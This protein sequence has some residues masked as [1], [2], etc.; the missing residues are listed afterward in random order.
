[1]RDLT[2]QRF[3]KLLVLSEAGRDHLGKVLWR[4]QCDCGETTTT[5]MGNLTQGTTKSCGCLRRVSRRR[6]DLTGRRFGLL[7]A[8]RPAGTTKWA[9]VCDCGVLKDV[10]TIH[11]MREHTRSC[12]CLRIV[13]NPDA[14]RLK[15]RER[16]SLT[17]WAKQAIADAHLQCDCCGAT[18]NLHAHHIMPFAE[19]PELRRDP[20][21]AAALCA[22]CHRE[23]HRLIRQGLTGG[24]ALATMLTDSICA[25][26]NDAST[27]AL[28]CLTAW[29]ENGGVEDLKKARHYLDK[30][31][32]VEGGNG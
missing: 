27:D 15:R 26:R 18:S 20:E 19:Y 21:N 16:M 4:C 7:T 12:G 3:A 2:G 32:E 11:L 28:Q 8:L 30:L 10:F 6:A 9:C 31:I 13:Q 23:V 14:A 29:R 22:P 5:T 1:M 24:D 25:R 17:G